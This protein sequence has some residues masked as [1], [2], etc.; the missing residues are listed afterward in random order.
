MR[1]FTLLKVKNLPPE[2]HANKAES[3]GREKKSYSRSRR[4]WAH[5]HD[6]ALS[7]QLVL[8]VKKKYIASL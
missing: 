2:T 8:C 4:A 1:V 6:Y 7:L 3:K 5:C